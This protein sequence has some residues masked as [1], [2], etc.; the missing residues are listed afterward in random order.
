M[1]QG[2]MEVAA[3]HSNLA[4]VGSDG[5]SIVLGPLAAN[6]ECQDL[7]EEEV[8][9]DGKMVRRQGA[10]RGCGVRRQ[11]PTADS[12]Q[13][14]KSA[15]ILHSTSTTHHCKP[16]QSNTPG[17]QPPT[18][19]RWR[20]RTGEAAV[21]PD[22]RG[23]CCGKGRVQS[24]VALSAWG[25]VGDGVTTT[26]RPA[27]SFQAQELAGISRAPAAAAWPPAVTLVKSAAPSGFSPQRAYRNWK[28]GVGLGKEGVGTRRAG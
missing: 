14:P 28:T 24:D 25:E 2:C 8:S 7:Q 15:S 12:L 16:P 1:S 9:S 19:A 21:T 22:L 18:R 26:T 6:G 17:T 27:C 4:H 20:P 5:L 23:R 3:G 11:Q 13:P 10:G